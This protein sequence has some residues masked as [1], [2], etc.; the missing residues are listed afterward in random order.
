MSIQSFSMDD[1]REQRRWLAHRDKKPFSPITGRAADWNKPDAWSDYETAKAKAGRDVGIVVGDGIVCID[2]DDALYPD[3]S[4][5]RV[6]PIFKPLFKLALDRG[7]YIEVS[8][9]GRGLHILLQ[10]DW[11][12][13]VQVKIPQHLAPDNWTKKTGIE[14][15]G[16]TEANGR[17][18]RFIAITGNTKRCGS[19]KF[20]PNGDDVLAL[21]F[22]LAETARTGVE[23]DRSLIAVDGVD[24]DIDGS[25]DRTEEDGQKPE[26]AAPITKVRDDHG[27]FYLL[28]RLAVLAADLWFPALFDGARKQGN[29]WRGTTPDA[30]R[31]DISLSPGGLRWWKDENVKTPIDAVMLFADPDREL[32]ASEAAAWLAERLAVQP[33]ALRGLAT[34][35]V[36]NSVEAPVDIFAEVPDQV[37]PWPAGTLPEAL[38]NYAYCMGQELGVNDAVLCLLFLITC[39]ACTPSGVRFQPDPAKSS[40]VVPAT[41]WGLVLAPSGAAKSPALDVALAPVYAVQDEWRNEHKSRV[42]AETD[43]TQKEQLQ[44]IGAKRK[45]TNASTTEALVKLF[46]NQPEGIIL[47]ADEVAGAFDAIGKYNRGS[48]GGHSDAA[49]LLSAYESKPFALDRKDDG[50][51]VSAER[52]HLSLIGGVQPAV[53][54]G[55]AESLSANGML[56]RALIAVMTVSLY[57]PPCGD[58]A[59]RELYNGVV[60]QIMR[61]GDFGTPELVIVGTPEIGAAMIAEGNKARGLMLSDPTLSETARTVLG[62]TTGHI[63]RLAI[64][65]QLIEWAIESYTITHVLDGDP[66]A[67]PVEVGIEVFRKAARIWWEYCFPTL[68]SVYDGTGLATPI[69][70]DARHVGAYVLGH[71]DKFAQPFSSRAFKDIRKFAGKAGLD[72]LFSALDYLVEKRWLKITARQPSGAPVF[73]VDD[74]IWTLFGNRAAASSTG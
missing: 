7:L 45:V 3:G 23:Q 32:A 54:S 66:V 17:A 33:T 47:H 53:L 10:S 9:S 31:E 71:E 55:M 52:A 41:A 11:S 39:G 4:T 1:L 65:L 30:S 42:N 22:A 14:V 62:K 67:L 70:N 56:Q 58:A 74:R 19:A 25:A 68:R 60:R 24:G 50:R 20:I 64:W 69:V 37:L 44:K 61:L 27:P 34:L 36:R 63:A 46:A 29:V 8:Q 57:G 59:G 21:A 26:E 38:E 49:V 2:L 35:L 43:K 72:R 15:Y 6:K 48:Q 13:S 28:N 73:A 16:G 40:W 12:G 18:R 5:S 51:S